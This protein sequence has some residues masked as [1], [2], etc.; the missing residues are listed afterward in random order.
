[1]RRVFLFFVLVLPLSIFAQQ[2]FR[3]KGNASGLKSGT[4]LYLFYKGGHQMIIDSS[5]VNAG[6]FSFSGNIEEPLKATLSLSPEIKKVGSDVLSFYLEPTTIVITMVDSFKSARLSGSILNADDAVYR[7]SSQPLLEEMVKISAALRNAGTEQKKDDRFLQSYAKQYTEASKKLFDVQLAFAR[8]HPDSYLSIAALTPMAESEVFIDDA[9][10][11]FLALSPSV[12]NTKA[13]W[14]AAEIFANGQRTKIGQAAIAFTQN[15]VN[16]KPVSLSDLKG[17]YVLIDFWAS[18]CAPCRKENPGLIAAYHRF[19]DRGF[20]ILGVSLDGPGARDAWLKA[21]ADDKLEWTQLSDLQSWDNEVAR[22]Y[23]V[24]SIPANFLVD[25]NGKLVAKG[26]R[27][28]RL[29]AKLAE[30]LGAEEKNK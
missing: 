14:A 27:G 3:V 11:A 4:K 5:T 30:L 9:E 22:A 29:V 28:D 18:W 21:I 12:K 15:D 1:M 25:R 16:G 6:F 13:G 19:K 7:Q 24:R 20:T 8:S 26:L 23:K 2:S 17:K 10:Q